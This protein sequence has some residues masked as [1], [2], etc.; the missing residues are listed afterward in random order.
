M[1]IVRNIIKVDDKLHQR[2]VPPPPPKTAGINLDFLSTFPDSLK[3]KLPE[4][5]LAQLPVKK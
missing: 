5:I 2:V 4:H 1:P 3:A